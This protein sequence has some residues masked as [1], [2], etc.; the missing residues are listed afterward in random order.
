[1]CIHWNPLRRARVDFSVLRDR[2]D[3]GTVFVHG[4]RAL[5]PPNLFRSGEE[6]SLLS[7]SS[8]LRQRKELLSLSLSLSLHC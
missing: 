6:R 3:G 7:L 8:P 2:R 4:T 1:M 5:S